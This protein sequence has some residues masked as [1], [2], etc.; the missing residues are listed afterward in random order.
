M[1]VGYKGPVD[2]SQGT[3]VHEV[4]QAVVISTDSAMMVLEWR[5]DNYDEFL[6]V[7]DSPDEAATTSIVDVVDASS[8]PPW[9]YLVDPAIAGFGVATQP[10]ESGRELLW[11]LRID[12][13]SAASVVVALG[14][15]R[16]GLPSY[17]P[18]SLLVI[19][20]PEMAQSYQ[21]LDAPESAW[22]RDLHL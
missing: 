16:D 19:S 6:G 5:I 14:D 12:F 1:H 17:S 4:D 7:V 21:V 13:E 9:R 20:D 2:L 22:G 18:D 10:S 8:L 11:A 15:L 3:S